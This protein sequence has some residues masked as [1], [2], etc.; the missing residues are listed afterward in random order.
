LILPVAGEAFRKLDEKGV[1]RIWFFHLVNFLA[2][3]VE[4]R[5]EFSWAAYADPADEANRVQVGP[6][7]APGRSDPTAKANA[8]ARPRGKPPSR[9]GGPRRPARRRRTK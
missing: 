2:R 1:L 3:E 7:V 6:A 4:R 5:K 9:K 8:K